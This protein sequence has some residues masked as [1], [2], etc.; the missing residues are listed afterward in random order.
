M[1]IV[2]EVRLIVDYR[3]EAPERVT[4]QWK[5]SLIAN[6]ERINA[7]RKAQIPDSTAFVDKLATPAI[8]AY[9]SFVNPAFQSKSGLNAGQIRANHG[10]NIKTAFEKYQGQLDFLFATVDGIPAKRFK[11]LVERGAA[12]YSKGMASVILPFTGCRIEGLG[13]TSIAGRWLTGDVTTEGK[14]R[15]GDS[16]TAG[17]PYRICPHAKKPGLK[18]LLN[19]RLIQAGVNIVKA[20]H[21]ASVIAAENQLTAE[22]VQ[23]LVDPGLDLIPFVGNSPD[24]HVDYIV[25]DGQLYLSIR[26]SKM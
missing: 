1:P 14:L 6:A 13:L 19:Q 22:E 15:A 20:A 5:E 12:D 11:D 21:D 26:V 3:P 24:S 18:T 23:G 10:A 4:Q 2:S 9:A 16:I 8:Q 17:G 25:V 7:K